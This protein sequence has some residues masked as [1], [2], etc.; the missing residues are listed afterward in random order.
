MPQVFAGYS[1]AL[2]PRL[3]VLCALVATCAAVN[4]AAG[5]PNDPPLG[6]VEIGCAVGGFVLSYKASL[7]GVWPVVGCVL[8]GGPQ[9]KLAG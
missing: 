2:K 8:G 1:H 6:L 5:D 4:A 7:L 9:G 3:L